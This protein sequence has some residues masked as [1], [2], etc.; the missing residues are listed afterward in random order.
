MARPLAFDPQKTLHRA[1]M[2]FWRKGYEATS[3]QDLVDT[4]E[5]NRYSIYNTLGDKQALFELC[6]EY[7]EGRVFAHL[8]EALQPLEAG[9][10]SLEHSAYPFSISR[11]KP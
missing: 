9:L 7:Y 2:L 8:L 4:L 1:T 6:L 10:P 11:G 3:M 5:I